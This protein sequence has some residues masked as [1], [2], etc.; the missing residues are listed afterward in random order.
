[1]AILEEIGSWGKA[2]CP[3]ICRRKRDHRKRLG[4][5]E[6]VMFLEH[7]PGFFD[8]PQ[9]L[10][11]NEVIAR[12]IRLLP[13]G[14]ETKQVTDTSRAVLGSWWRIIDLAHQTIFRDPRLHQFI[15]TQAGRRKHIECQQTEGG[16]CIQRFHG[17]KNA[18]S[19]VLRTSHERRIS[20]IMRPTQQARGSGEKRLSVASFGVC[21][22]PLT[23]PFLLGLHF[24]I[25]STD[26]TIPQETKFEQI[27]EPWPRRCCIIGQASRFDKLDER[28]IAFISETTQLL[29][30]VGHCLATVARSLREHKV[31][32]IPET[33]MPALRSLF[34]GKLSRK[35]PL[36]LLR[37]RNGF[38]VC[39]AQ[40]DQTVVPQ[41]SLSTFGGVG[42]PEQQNILE[43]PSH[44]QM[45]T[46]VLHICHGC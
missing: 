21:I 42:F 13:F 29:L 2:M 19:T 40:T 24:L 16:R 39:L 38:L 9:R 30:G 35:R 26:W 3:P 7:P 11:P 43:H 10:L 34:V 41:M 37:L 14:D 46:S 32:P 8:Q 28:S 36:I 15:E 31:S 33:K 23:K 17:D 1:M 20:C 12:C 18:I 44:A 27:G 5:A 22:S 25:C 6:L 45:R 4:S